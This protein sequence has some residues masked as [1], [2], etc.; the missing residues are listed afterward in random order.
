MLLKSSKAVSDMEYRNEL[1]ERTQ[2]NLEKL[3]SKFRMKEKD[4]HDKRFNKILQSLKRPSKKEVELQ[5]AK[6][7][8]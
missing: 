3:H 8:A 6:E 4:H 5:L 2:Q 1:F 7:L